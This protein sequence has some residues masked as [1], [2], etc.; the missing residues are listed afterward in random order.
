MLRPV[1][2]EWGGQALAGSRRA[3]A[4]LRAGHQPGQGVRPA[5]CGPGARAQRR[6][7]AVLGP[8]R[9]LQHRH[10]RH[11]R[12]QGQGAV[13]LLSANRE[14]ISFV[15]DQLSAD[16][17]RAKLANGDF[18]ELADVPDLVWKKVPGRV[19]GG[20]DVTTN[21]GPEHP[22]HY[23]DI[24]RPGARR[25]HAAR[26]LP[27]RQIP[28]RRRG[29]AGIL[30]RH[31]RDGRTVP[32]AAAAARVAVLRRD[33]RGITGRRHR[34][35]GVRHGRRVALHRR[36]LP[37]AARVH[38]VGRLSGP[39][40]AGGQGLARPRRALD[41][42]GQDGGPL[43]GPIAGGHWPGGEARRGGSGAADRQRPG[44]GVCGGDADG[45]LRHGRSRRASCATAI[46]NWAAA[47]PN[48]S[49]KDYGTR[50]AIARRH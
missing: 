35:R 22:N 38:A 18:V 47:R 30:R 6:R 1:A 50:S 37:A 9:S 19:P 23:A 25:A 44:R 28:G 4:Q 33:R 49:S 39:G 24:D 20:R 29:L 26:H 45:L 41:L 17:I 15:P 21:T 5:G 8:G 16:Q 14:R 13:R 40:G 48:P 7:H 36:R 10:R 32:R 3:A 12:R 2:V 42:R 31:Q 46:S 11:R 34:A 43:L 27:G